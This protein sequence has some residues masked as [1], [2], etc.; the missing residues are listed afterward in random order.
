MIRVLGL[1]LIRVLGL[2]LISGLRLGLIRV[3]GLGL[4]RVL[5]LG[6]ASVLGSDGRHA[7]E[8][9]KRGGL[10]GGTLPQKKKHGVTKKIGA[11]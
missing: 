4:I 9:N 3:L 1:G 10:G 7:P 5:G 6:F 8:K 2:G 11:P